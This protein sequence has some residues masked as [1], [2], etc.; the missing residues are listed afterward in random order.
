M[1]LTLALLLAL[2]AHFAGQLD[3][4]RWRTREQAQQFLTLVGM[5][6]T[7]SASPEVARR[8]ALLHRKQHAAHER[9]LERQWLAKPLGEMPRLS[10]YWVATGP[11]SGENIY[12]RYFNLAMGLSPTECFWPPIVEQFA[13]HGIYEREAARLFLADVGRRHGFDGQHFRS[14]RHYLFALDALRGPGAAYTTNL[15]WEPNLWD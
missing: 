7:R 15:R 1:N 13:L 3:S 12:Y 11:T 10:A 5:T 2:A 9:Q 8:V 6:P 4:P 14:T